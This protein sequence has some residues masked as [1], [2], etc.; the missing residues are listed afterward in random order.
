MKWQEKYKI[1]AERVRG[2][3]EASGLTQE[4]LAEKIDCSVQT[5]SNIECGKYLSV[6]KAVKLASVFNVPHDYLLG[7]IGH[8][9]EY[10]RLLN[11]DLSLMYRA[12]SARETLVEYLVTSEGNR[13]LKLSEAEKELLMNEIMWFG[14]VR[15]KRIIQERGDKNAKESK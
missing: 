8:P 7:K 10:V 15:L 9:D 6:D 12:L 13:K 14:R 5:I 11:Q 2:C 1:S 4:E 3:R